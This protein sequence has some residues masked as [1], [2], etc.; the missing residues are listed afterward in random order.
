MKPLFSHVP[1]FQFIAKYAGRCK[2]LQTHE[3]HVS[4]ITSSQKH[5]QV[6]RGHTYFAVNL[7]LM[8]LFRQLFKYTL[9]TLTSPWLIC[10]SNLKT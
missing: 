9:K 5:C 8:F 10:S 6:T 3:E 4:V 7:A 2:H 1:P